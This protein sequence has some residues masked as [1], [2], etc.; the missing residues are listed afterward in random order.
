MSASKEWTEWHLTPNGW[1]RGSDKIN[2]GKITK[3]NPPKDRVISFRLTEEYSGVFT[4]PDRTTDQI[5]SGSDKE[6]INNLLDKYGEC[7]NKL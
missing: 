3:K 4:K 2:S 5:W 1:E 6:L 7:P